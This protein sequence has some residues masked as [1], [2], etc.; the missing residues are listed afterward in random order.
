MLPSPVTTLSGVVPDVDSG[1]D[2][3]VHRQQLL[4]CLGNLGVRD[5]EVAAVPCSETL[6]R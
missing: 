6:L 2:H 4:P 1:L 5:G 3:L